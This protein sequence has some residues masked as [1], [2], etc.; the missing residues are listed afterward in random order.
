[1]LNLKWFVPCSTRNDLCASVPIDSVD[2]SD[3]TPA[4]DQL[5]A[6]LTDNQ[7]AMQA[8]FD[9]IIAKER[10]ERLE[11]ERVRRE[12]AQLRRAKKLADREAAAAAAERASE[13]MAAAGEQEGTR[14]LSDDN[15]M[16]F[17]GL[18]RVEDRSFASGLETNPHI[19]ES[20]NNGLPN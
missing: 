14:R 4:H 8:Q 11:K 13:E 5:Y 12:K 3:L 17:D 2:A 16:D 20:S 7:L 9:A 10:A 18:G 6:P 19:R 1:M 15:E